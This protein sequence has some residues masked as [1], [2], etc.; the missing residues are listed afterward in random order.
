M[1]VEPLKKQPP[2]PIAAPGGADE[3]P[4]PE[5][6]AAIKDPARLRL[7][8][9]AAVP[10]AVVLAGL[11]AFLMGG[12]WVTTDNAAIGADLAPVT[13]EVQ[14]MIAQVHVAEGQVVKAGDPLFTLDQDPFKLAL[15]V[16]QS[17]EQ[18]A[19]IKLSTLKAQ[20]QKAASDIAI[21][22][23][24]VAY[25]GREVT[26]SNELRRRDV[27]SESAVDKVKSDLATAQGYMGSLEAAAASALAA[28]AGDPD[29]P[30]EKFPDYISARA[31][32]LKAE[33]DLRKATIVA[34]IDGMVSKT[35]QLVPG[36]VISPGAP[37]LSLIATRN[38][39]VDANPKET[40]L[41]HVAV[42]QKAEVTVDAFPGRTFTGTV[43]AISPGTGAKYSVLPAQNASGNWVKVVQRVPLRIKLDSAADAPVLR[44]GMSA[45]V[46]IDTGYRRSIADLF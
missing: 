17:Q 14:G 22:K 3:A 45:E 18:A 43:V 2:A 10:L 29:L 26:R 8:L 27:T 16:A 32:I 33:R 40:D 35:E 34:G 5:M 1:S 46:A 38:L 23:A 44:A 41:T 28:L 12:R 7:I 21:A 9:L 30:L 6:I 4:L 19:R 25:R 39:W 36:R 31:M 42:G 11:A 24:A 15:V 20:Y 13:A 37:V